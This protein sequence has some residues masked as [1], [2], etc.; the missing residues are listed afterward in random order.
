MPPKLSATV[1]D[2]K[3]TPKPTNKP[4]DV[5]LVEAMLIA[6]GYPRQIKGKISPQL[7]KEI[8][9]FQKNKGKAKDPSGVIDAKDPAWVKGYPKFVT[10][11]DQI[12]SFTAYKVKENGKEKM[13]TVDEYLRMEKDCR[14]NMERT[15]RNMYIDADQIDRLIT[16]MHKR[17]DGSA[18]FVNALAHMGVSGWKGIEIPKAKAALDA[19]AAATDLENL[20]KRTKVDWKKV[21]EQQKRA[22]ALLN[23]A[24]KEW[25]AYEKVYV[26]G[27]E[28][29]VVGA[30]IV[31][32]GSFAVLETLAT[33][34]LVTTRGMPLKK[35][36]VLAAAGCEGLKVTAGEIG[37]YAANDKVDIAKSA[38]KIVTGMAIAG[39]AKFLGGKIDAKFLTKVATKAVGPIARRF[40]SS[41]VPLYLMTVYVNKIFSS[42]IGS[43]ML[44]NAVEETFKTVSGSLAKGKLPDEKAIMDG[45]VNALLGAFTG[46]LPI[47]SLQKF[48]DK[49]AAKAYDAMIDDFSPTYKKAIKNQL[50]KHFPHEMVSKWVKV[51]GDDAIQSVVQKVRDEAFKTGMKGAIESATGTEKKP[52]DFEKMAKKALARDKQLQDKVQMM[53]AIRAKAE[54]KKMAKAN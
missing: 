51:G 1:G 54:M 43:E 41:G 26:E 28:Q 35:A 46:C 49:W 53:L 23:K 48:D 42:T 16:Q 33:A 24:T 32:E 25:K 5:E 44:K 39:G 13:I 21:N 4:A 47:K 20:V 3:A 29:G 7:I 22:R 6:N 40:A 52:E 9:F 18:G 36:E 27:A 12:T 15:A 30:T 19:R 11:Y 8:K 14:Y 34:Y 17:A 50:V 37:E 45:S 31:R 10:Y 38:Q 2:P